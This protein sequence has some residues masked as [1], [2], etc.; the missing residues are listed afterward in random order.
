MRQDPTLEDLTDK[1]R[2][3]VE[4]FL[5]LGGDQG[6]ATEAV[7]KTNP[8]IKSREVARQTA[9]RH[10]HNPRVL[11]V[12][13]QMTEGQ[14]KIDAVRAAAKLGEMLDGT[15]NGM[16][17]KS[18]DV[19]KAAQDIL[20]RAGLAGVQRVEHTHTDNRSLEEIKEAVRQQLAQMRASGMDVSGVIDVE[21]TPVLKELM[22]P[23]TAA[24]YG[25]TKHGT[26]C[27]KPGKKPYKRRLTPPPRPTE[28]E[29]ARMSPEKAARARAM[30]DARDERERLYQE[31]QEALRP[32]RIAAAKS[33]WSK[34]REKSEVVSDPV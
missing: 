2:A 3:F 8:D 31:R 23:D 14:F 10:L 19:L 12:L 18:S 9:Y 21:A 16:P 17:V 24:P 4:A 22:G 25:R 6:A 29:F 13:R 27:L 5:A 33:R 1:Q 11:A 26:P 30:W 28:E 7:V 34:E 32:Q 20:N 15:V